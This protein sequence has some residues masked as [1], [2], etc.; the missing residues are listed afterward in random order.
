MVSGGRRRGARRRGVVEAISDPKL[1]RATFFK[2]YKNQK[3]KLYE[4][5]TLC[6]VEAF[7]ICFG[8]NG[9]LHTWPEDPRELRR[10]LHRY[11]GI[12]R[13]EREKRVTGVADFVDARNKK[14]E[15]ELKRVKKKENYDE[16]MSTTS[17]I[18][19]W[20]SR[21]DGFGEESMKELLCSLEN[22]INFLKE[23]IETM[24]SSHDHDDENT[25]THHMITTATSEMASLVD[26]Q[27]TPNYIFDDD[28]QFYH[29]TQPQFP[30]FEQPVMYS[31]E[32]YNTQFTNN[33]Q[34]FGF[35]LWDPTMGS[36]L[37]NNPFSTGA[38]YEAQPIQA[39]MPPPLGLPPVPL[40]NPTTNYNFQNFDVNPYGTWF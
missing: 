14:L 29:Q 4:L 21:M 33:S 13:S 26:H 8:P 23:K 5:T 40:T 31:V 9:E 37:I 11:M 20:D 18:F 27:I 30:V 22:N 1:R 2:R 7:M 10:V 38:V 25:T 39:I 36:S 3:K 24:K 28:S 12:Q 17:K 34:F 6:D 15:W 16:E 35:E 19:G 32:H